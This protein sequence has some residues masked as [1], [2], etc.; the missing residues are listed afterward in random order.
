MK[1]TKQPFCDTI[2][3]MIRR[4]VCACLLLVLISLE[5]F[6]LS[7]VGFANQGISSEEQSRFS[8]AVFADSRMDDR[9]VEGKT[10]TGDARPLLLETYLKKYGSPLV[11]YAEQIFRLSVKNGYDYRWIVAIAQQESNLCKKIPKDSH[12]CWGYG[13]HSRGTM[14]FDSYDEALASY[15][16]Y[17]KREYFDKGL[18]TSEQIM[19]KY[20]PFS[21]GSWAFGVNQFMREIEEAK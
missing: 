2:T 12:N 9:Q 16:D 5:V 10:V 21:E 20:A 8:A 6:S 11:P 17:L 13:I 19:R 4:G 3:T 7:K 1:L 18:V 15:S 14:M